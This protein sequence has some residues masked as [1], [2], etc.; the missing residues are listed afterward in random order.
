[1][2]ARLKS[3]REKGTRNTVQALNDHNDVSKLPLKV[4]GESQE[5]GRCLTVLSY[6]F[7]VTFFPCA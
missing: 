3:E 2:A 1:M 4:G 5:H 6:F 7:A